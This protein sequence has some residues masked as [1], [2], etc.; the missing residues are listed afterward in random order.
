MTRKHKTIS[1]NAIPHLAS[2]THVV[3]LHHRE[4]AWFGPCIAPIPA[5]NSSKRLMKLSQMAK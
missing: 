1:V 3:R 2:S 4:A 5:E